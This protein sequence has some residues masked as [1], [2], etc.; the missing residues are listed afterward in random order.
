MR[1]RLYLAPDEFGSG[2]TVIPTTE[3]AQ[4]QEQPQIELVDFAAGGKVYKVP[5]EVKQ[6]FGQSL[7]SERSALKKEIEIIQRSLL[8]KDKTN[9]Q[10]EKQQPISKS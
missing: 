7:S 5:K 10:P 3:Q 4:G 8:D 9:K 1:I 6:A 2:G